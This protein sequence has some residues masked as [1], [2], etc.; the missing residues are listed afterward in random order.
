M[1]I[2]ENYRKQVALLIRQCLSSHSPDHSLI[3]FNSELIVSLAS[4]AF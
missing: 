2:A 4:V 1:A 3:I